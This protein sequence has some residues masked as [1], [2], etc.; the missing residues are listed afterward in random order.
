MKSNLC[1]ILLAIP[2]LLGPITTG[3][4]N[5]T[6]KFYQVYKD[7]SDFDTT[8]LWNKAKLK[9]TFSN[10]GTIY[11]NHIR[12]SVKFKLR[13]TDFEEIY[14][15]FFSAKDY[16]FFINGWRL[17]KFKDPDYGTSIAVYQW[18][19]RTWVIY[20]E[21]ARPKVVASRK[22]TKPVRKPNQRAMK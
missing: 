11:Y 4:Q 18:P 3:A 21:R 1:F 9:K 5:M 12:N 20:R 16:L 14:N 19:K 8:V 17:F 7:D 10:R 22:I 6:F 13:D 2:W 15:V